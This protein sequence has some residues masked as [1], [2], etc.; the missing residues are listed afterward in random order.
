MGRCGVVRM[1]GVLVGRRGGLLRRIA[2]LGLLG[3]GFLLLLA[4]N[5]REQEHAQ[6][7]NQNRRRP[8]GP[9]HEVTNGCEQRLLLSIR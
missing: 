7:Q 6:T 4:A 9:A 1:S 5:G 8:T 3:R 2:L